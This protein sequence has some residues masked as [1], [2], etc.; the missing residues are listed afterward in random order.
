LVFENGFGIVQQSPD[1]GAFAA[2]H[3]ARGNETQQLASIKLN[4]IHRD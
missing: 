2:V 4:S 3:A 1:Q